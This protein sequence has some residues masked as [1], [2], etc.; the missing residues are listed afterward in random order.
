MEEGSLAVLVDAKT[1]Y[2][3]QFINIVKPCV[4]KSVHNLF[5]KSKKSKYVLKKFQ[6]ELSQIP[7]WNQDIIDK[8]YTNIM[9]MS[10]CDWL[11]DLITAV[12]LSHTRILTSINLSKDKGKI[13]LKIPLRSHFIH[14]CYVDVARNIWKNSLLFDDR[15]SNKDKQKNRR[16]CDKIIEKSIIETIRKEL[17]LKDLLKEFLDNDFINNVNPIKSSIISKLNNY[18]DEKLNEIK[19]YLETEPKE[20]PKEEVNEEPKEEVK[21]E[22]KEELVEEPKEE[23]KEEMKEELVEPKEEPKEEMKEE[24]VEPKEEPKEEVKEELVEEPKEETLNDI[25]QIEELNLDDFG[26][27][28]EVYDETT[29]FGAQP[30]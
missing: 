2:T 27:Y 11:D 13:N 20:E 28:E 1:E 8:E 21:E 29:Y 18:S 16:E 15:V 26:N 23:A 14:K 3:Q 7:L 25:L 30:I 12:F 19:T 10:N 6:E 9:S 24:L 17:P 4:Y 22:A 5:I